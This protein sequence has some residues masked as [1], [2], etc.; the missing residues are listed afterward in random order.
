MTVYK[1]ATEEELENFVSVLRGKI[2]EGKPL[3]VTN[4][5]ASYHVGGKKKRIEW[6]FTPDAVGDSV[7]MKKDLMLGVYVKGD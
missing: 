1:I 5:V 4:S 2:K 7:S 3:Y 6:Y